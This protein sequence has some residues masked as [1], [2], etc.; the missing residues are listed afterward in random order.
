MADHQDPTTELMNLLRELNRNQIQI[1]ETQ[2]LMQ[3]TLQKLSKGKT[4]GEQ[5]G[6]SDD[7]ISGRA[8]FQPSRSRPSIPIFLPRMEAPR[9]GREPTFEEMQEKL[10]EDWHNAN[11]EGDISYR[12]YVDLG[13]RYFGEGNH[14]YFNDDL[15]RKIRKVNLSPFNGSRAITT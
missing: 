14:G 6:H 3:E 9:K 12:D 10:W 15:M 2:R 8:N 1:N 4:T 5:N 11:M 13:M 7:S